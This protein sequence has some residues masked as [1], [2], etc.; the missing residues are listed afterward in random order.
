[1]KKEAAAAAATGAHLVAAVIKDGK[2]QPNINHSVEKKVQL[3][4]I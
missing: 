1:V 3:I 2:A 4:N